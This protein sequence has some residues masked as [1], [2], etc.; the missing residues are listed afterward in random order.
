ML[1]EIQG[2]NKLMAN[3]YAP[4]RDDPAFFGLLEKKVNDIAD[5]PIIMGSDFN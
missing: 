5:Y 4:N 1:C 2:N 3:V